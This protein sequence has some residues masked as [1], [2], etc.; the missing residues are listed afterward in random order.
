MA[1]ATIPVVPYRCAFA[2]RPHVN[3]GLIILLLAVV[4]GAIWVVYTY[5]DIVLTLGIGAIAI[6]IVVPLA[7][8]AVRKYLYLANEPPVRRTLDQED[9][10]KALEVLKNI[11]ATDSPAVDRAVTQHLREAL[12][13]LRKSNLALEGDVAALKAQAERKL[14]ISSNNLEDRL[15]AATDSSVHEDYAIAVLE[16]LAKTYG[17][18]VVRE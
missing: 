9:F 12:F 6:A 4:A 8:W 15:R 14:R 18:R 16:Q 1:H 3:E 13:A 11:P 7:V 2:R 17:R 10:H 5:W